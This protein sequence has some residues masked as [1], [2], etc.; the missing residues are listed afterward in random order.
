MFV[1]PACAGMIRVGAH[2]PMM[3]VGLPRMRGDDPLLDGLP[4]SPVLFAP[5]A[6]G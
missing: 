5:H 6:R 2:T 4:R 1:C 3:Q